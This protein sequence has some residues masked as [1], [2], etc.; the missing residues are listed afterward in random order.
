MKFFVIILAVGLG[1]AMGAVARKLLGMLFHEVMGLPDYVAIMIV[2]IAGCFLIGF[3]FFCLEGLLKKDMESR[4]Q[5]TPL[6]RPLV[7]RGWWPDQDPTQPVV[8]D[9]KKD[10]RAELLAAF[11]ITGILGGMTTFSLFSLL[12]LNLVQAGNHTAML[13]NAV[14]TVLLG[15]LATYLGLALGSR[16]ILKLE[17]SSG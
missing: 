6:A 7:N 2:N 17:R 8:S 12:S 4:L 10:L 16:L 5:K 9:F 14:G 11:I 3:V 13:I 1:G 15:W